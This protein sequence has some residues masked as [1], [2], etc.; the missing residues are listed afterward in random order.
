MSLCGYFFKNT[1]LKKLLI[2]NLQ[3]G[4]KNKFI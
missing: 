1:S 3:L 2:V 4:C